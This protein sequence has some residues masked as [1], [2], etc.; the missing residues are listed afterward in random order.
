MGILKDIFRLKEEQHNFLKNTKDLSSIEAQAMMKDINKRV[1]Y[2]SHISTQGGTT[3]F[4]LP[5][6][7][8]KNATMKALTLFQRI[9]YSVTWDTYKNYYKPIVTHRNMM[10]LARATLAQGIGGYALVKLYDSLF[11]V[12][13]PADG[14]DD[15]F[16]RFV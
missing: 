15:N 6:W 4:D 1:D 8:T 13:P 14:S 7:A 2:F 16:K 9:A 5:L 11:G 3:T 10:P 12:E